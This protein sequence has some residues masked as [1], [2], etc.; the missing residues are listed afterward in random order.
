MRILIVEDDIQVANSVRAGLIAAAHFAHAVN[1]VE[2]ARIAL[3][4]EPFDLAIIDLGLPGADGLS[5]VRSLRKQENRL[6]ILILTARDGLADR[7]GALDLGADDYMIKP[8]DLAELVARCRALYRRTH[9]AASGV[10]DVGGLRVDLASREVR[11][12]NRAIALT[13]SEWA[14]LERLAT[15]AGRMIDKEHLRAALAQEEREP[16]VH[17]LEACVSRLRAKL[18]DAVSITALRGLGYRLDDS[19][20]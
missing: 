16:S 2:Q 18:G 6:P 3:N 1:T 11:S 9:G 17:A 7:V 20:Y 5:L 15:Q 12:G 4:T 10:L 8:F 14:V 13:R 19:G